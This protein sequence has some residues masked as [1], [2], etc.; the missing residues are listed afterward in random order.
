[1]KE[2]NTYTARIYVGLKEGY[3]GKQ[4]DIS[5]VYEVLQEFCD[6]NGFA[7]EVKPTKYIYT[8]GN[9]DGVDIGIINYPRFPKSKEYIQSIS[10]VIALILLDEFKQERCTVVCT[11]KTFMLEKSDIETMKK[12][13]YSVGE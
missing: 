6:K 13:S 9:E 8:N 11:D 2:V 1:M 12:F 3:D 4:H 5:E 7:F 10:F